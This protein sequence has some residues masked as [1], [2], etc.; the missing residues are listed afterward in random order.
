[1]GEITIHRVIWSDFFFV[2]KYFV[3]TYTY[4]EKNILAILVKSLLSYY[5]DFHHQRKQVKFLLSYYDDFY[6]GVCSDSQQKSLEI[7]QNQVSSL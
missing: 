7:Q 2:S 4:F 6:Q 1:M 3:F 5:D